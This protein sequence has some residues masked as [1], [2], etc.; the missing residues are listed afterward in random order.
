[1]ISCIVCPHIVWL[2]RDILALAIG[3]CAWRI[4][5]TRYFSAGSLVSLYHLKQDNVH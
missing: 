3:T 5:L 2:E 4:D 1:V